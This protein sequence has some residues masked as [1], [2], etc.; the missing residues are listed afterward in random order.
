MGADVM[1]VAPVAEMVVAAVVA[2]AAAE[3]PEGWPVVPAIL[4]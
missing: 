4:W 3:S 2:F 1:V